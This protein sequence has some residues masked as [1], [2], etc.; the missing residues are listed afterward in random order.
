MPLTEFPSIFPQD[1]GVEAESLRQERLAAILQRLLET[2]GESEPLPQRELEGRPGGLETIFR[3]VLGTATLGLVPSSRTFAKRLLPE[4]PDLGLITGPGEA[5]SAGADILT[6]GSPEFDRFAEL[7][8]Q[9]KEEQKF[10]ETTN[11]LGGVFSPQDPDR[12]GSVLERGGQQGL[13]NILSTISTLSQAES[14][15]SG[16]SVPINATFTDPD[17][18]ETV[19][20]K[21]FVNPD[22]TY[23]AIE[24]RDPESGKLVSGTAKKPEE[25]DFLNLTFDENAQLTSL[26]SGKTQ[27][28]RAVLKVQANEL[29][30]ETGRRQ[31]R[32]RNVRPTVAKIMR[33]SAVLLRDIGRARVTGQDDQ[34]VV[35]GVLGR[36]LGG[37]DSAA[38]QISALANNGAGL[39]GLT[40]DEFR[41]STVR[42]VPLRLPQRFRNAI[43]NNAQI[44]SSV[45]TLAF[46]VARS[47]EQDTG[48]ITDKDVI[49]AIETIGAGSGSP[50]QF[51]A[52]IRRMVS[53]I[54]ANYTIDLRDA[55]GGQDKTIER[56]D[57]RKLLRQTDLDI[58]FGRGAR[59]V[60]QSSGS[61]II[62][63]GETIDFR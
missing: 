39:T 2:T 4:P 34:N 57:A 3:G 63:S 58:L 45:N 22:G 42:G 24:I 18:G 49:R 26:T 60:P 52:S 11:F 14:R 19:I 62:R 13:T 51:E 55:F 41:S 50:D 32:V 5:L 17:T 46:L 16:E 1:I 38:A 35:L 15:A 36:A 27:D 7:I 12:V 30:R 48:R 54:D 28:T 6:P 53:D 31:G 33:G 61:S 9:V 56:L 23:S 8:A 25:S 40:R 29:L 47:R 10:K 21:F 44:A 43:V 59:G 20:G 37:L